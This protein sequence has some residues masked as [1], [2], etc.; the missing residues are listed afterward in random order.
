[1]LTSVI[2][3]NHNTP[4]VLK[5]CIRSI[6]KFENA[7]N[8]EIIIIDN[9]SKDN[10][11]DVI[12]DLCSNHATVSS[13]FLNELKSFSLA[14]N[15]GI[16]KSKGKYVLI[17]NPDII[18]TEPVIEK[19][20]KTI[21]ADNEIGAISPALTGA[22]GNFQR[23]YFQRYPTIRQ[24]IYYHSII[25]KLFNRSADRMNRYLE[26]QDIDIDTGRL[27]FTEQIPC[28]FLLTIRSMFDK[29][30]LMDENFILFFED[31]DLSYRL[32][33][34]YKIAVDTSLRIIHLGG[35]SFKTDDNW[36]MYGRFI[37]S[38]VYFF[39]KHYG[40]PRATLLKIIVRLNSYSAL[41]IENFRRIFGT[42]DVYR[43]RKHRNLLQLLKESK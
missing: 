6:F 36:W 3:V 43:F 21:E 2:I 39:D 7:E 28:A 10:S 34:N 19:L 38:M 16:E 14:N 18:F 20:I 12:N 17:M 27:Y 29:I 42:M 13:I 31:V 35:T 23:N 5:D 1:L 15:R 4:D 11:A 9:A 8:L 25:A 22:D 26:N 24:F 32:N 41:L 40:K 37:T 33:K 30:G